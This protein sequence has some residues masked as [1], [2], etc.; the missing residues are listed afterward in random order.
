MF[1]FSKKKEKVEEKSLTQI[2]RQAEEALIRS[3]QDL[4]AK[5]E[6]ARLAG[7]NFK[8]WISWPE[9]EVAIVTQGTMKKVFIQGEE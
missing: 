9:K 6:E 3:A 7:S 1:G 4:T 2:K 8:P 5:W